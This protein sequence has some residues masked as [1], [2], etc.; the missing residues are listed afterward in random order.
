METLSGQA[1]FVDNCAFCHGADGK[2]NGFLAQELKLAP[3]D[4][5][6]LSKRT[7]GT[8]PSD[9]VMAVLEKGAGKTGDGDKAMPAWG[10][11]FAH[12]CGSRFKQQAILQLKRYLETIQAR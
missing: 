1:L 4:L 7:N 10:K 9:H 6:Q 5:T 12:E 2:G 3:P 8:F 11:I